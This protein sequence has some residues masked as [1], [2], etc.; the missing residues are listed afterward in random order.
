[1][2]TLHVAA[3]LLST[4]LVLPAQDVPPQPPSGQELQQLA[5]DQ[6]WNQIVLL[7]QPVT[8]R[9]AELDF[10]CGEALAQLG[11]FAEAQN[12]F[13]AG[14]RLA[15]SDPRFPVELAGIAFKQKNYP[16]TI[17]RLRQSLR[18]APG[19]AYANDFLGTAYF[20]EGNLE[21]ALKYWNRVGKPHDRRCARRS[22]HRASRPRCSTTPS[23][24]LRPARSPC[25]NFSTPTRAS[26]ASASFRNSTS[27]STLATTATSMLS[28]APTSLTAL[29][30]ASWNRSFSSF[31]V[32]RSR[33][34]TRSS[35]T[36]IAKPSISTPCSAGTRKNGA[37]S[38]SFPA[39]SSTAPNTA[40]I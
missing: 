35:I 18:L 22:L 7:L 31:K 15:P 20:L 1:M 11:R 23:P 6:H 37:S 12:A 36:C 29:A 25:H 24:S 8:A 10:Y 30:T 13:E 33:R 32:S 21:A 39:P 28:S 3:A 16:Q 38:R 9:S 17:R 4:C 27:I 5:A 2:R 19:D 26:A 40:G 14:R 34:S